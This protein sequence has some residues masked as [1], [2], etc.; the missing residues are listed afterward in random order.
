[1]SVALNYLNQQ[2][3]IITI[4]Y[5]LKLYRWFSVSGFHQGEDEINEEL[6]TIHHC[7]KDPR[8][9]APIYNKYHDQLFLF[10]HKRVDNLDIAADLT[11]RV[12]FK[13]LKNIRHYEP[14]GVPFSAW[15]YRIAINEV[16]AFFRQQKKMVR[17]VNIDENHIQYFMTEIDEQPLADPHIL[18]P[19]LL[20]QLNER[21]IEFIELRFFENYSFKEMGYLLGLTEVNAKVKTYRILKKLKKIAQE[22]RYN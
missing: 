13:C 10:I 12:F 21:E 20:E 17:T 15:L 3:L 8:H 22:V 18:V 2:L 7:Q 4:S 1:M 14:K 9:F 5:Q 16:N 6:K 19:V 11:S